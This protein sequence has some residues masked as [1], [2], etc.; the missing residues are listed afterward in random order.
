MYLVIWYQEDEHEIIYEGKS[1][2]KAKEIA[3]EALSL[4][5]SDGFRVSIYQIVEEQYK[6]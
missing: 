5:G 1:Y 6:S 3:D 2:E 4:L